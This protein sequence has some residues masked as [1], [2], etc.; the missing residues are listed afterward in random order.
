[1]SV[2]PLVCLS[3]VYLLYLSYNLS[4][5]P[6]SVYL[7]TVYPSALPLMSVYC[8]SIHPLSVHCLSI[9]L[10]ST[11]HSYNLPVCLSTACLASHLSLSVSL[12]FSSICTQAHLLQVSLLLPK[13]T[14]TNDRIFILFQDSSAGP[15]D[16]SD[17]SRTGYFQACE[18]L[19]TKPPQQHQWYFVILPSQWR[20]PN[21]T[22]HTT[23]PLQFVQSERCQLNKA[24]HT[25]YLLVPCDSPHHS[26]INRIR[27]RTLLTS[28]YFAVPPIATASIE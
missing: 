18:N 14:D 7:S 5:C 26:S 1:M 3:A 6:L 28:W 2:C 13:R 8:L 11:C 24:Q 16:Y 21:V 10:L 20:Q 9:Y 23:N 22:Q 17:K 19:G 25:T 27:P 15:W 12:S 4:T